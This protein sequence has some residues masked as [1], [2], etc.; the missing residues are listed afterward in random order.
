MF[1]VDNA[2]ATCDPG[3]LL[4]PEAAGGPDKG[5]ARPTVWVHR[6]V[7]LAVAS[8]TAQSEAAIACR[9]LTA[10]RFV[11]EALEFRADGDSIHHPARADAHFVGV[12]AG[13]RTLGAVAPNPAFVVQ[14]AA[15][16]HAR[17]RRRRR[18]RRRWRRRRRNR[19]RRSRGRACGHG[20][21]HPRCEQP[22]APT[23][24]CRARPRR[25]AR[26]VVHVELQRA[27][28]RVA[29]FASLL[30]GPRGSSR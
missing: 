23:G 11:V 21:V 29:A 19:G 28:Q 13:P 2:D 3:L 20:L 30:E 22:V 24:R 10:A 15:L 6:G 5:F 8:P 1:D 25:E 14:V 18:R 17:A 27:V 12:L 4:A 16:V 9:G 26:E 7:R